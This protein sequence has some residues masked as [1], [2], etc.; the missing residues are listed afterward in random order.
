MICECQVKENPD[1]KYRLNQLTLQ[2]IKLDSLNLEDFSQ[3]FIKLGLPNGF[4][5]LCA[6]LCNMWCM[7]FEENLFTILMLR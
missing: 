3:Y 7:L 1:K 6:I 4:W 5:R 2:I